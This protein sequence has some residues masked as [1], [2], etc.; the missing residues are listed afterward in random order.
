MVT[1]SQREK[2]EE[3]ECEADR[4]L[5]KERNWRTV[6]IIA[7]STIFVMLLSDLPHE[8]VTTVWIV[9]I[10]SL[11]MAERARDAR[12]EIEDELDELEDEIAVEPK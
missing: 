11:V 4:F 10:G 7:F 5:A 8:W 1:E 2:F 12:Y 6:Q 3:L 9:M